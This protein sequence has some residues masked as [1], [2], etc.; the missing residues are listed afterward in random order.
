MDAKEP[1]DLTA[2]VARLGIGWEAIVED[3]A[4]AFQA[5][6]VAQLGE[7]FDWAALGR[8][9]VDGIAAGMVPLP[10]YYRRRARRWQAALLLLYVVVELLVRIL[11]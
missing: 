6:L 5:E 1:D 3:I 8:G 10:W 2:A 4:T 9:V 7:V 11:S